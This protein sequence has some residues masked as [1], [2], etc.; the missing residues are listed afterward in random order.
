MMTLKLE[1]TET[2]LRSKVYLSERRSEKFRQRNE[3]ALL[4]I[5]SSIDIT[6]RIHLATAD[7][8]CNTT[9]HP[10]STR[11]AQQMHQNTLGYYSQVPLLLLL[12][13][14]LLVWPSI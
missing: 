2:I 5:A 8:I 9:N 7:A 3:K 4:K 6:A 11:F 10:S 12:I 1:I 14:L 13:I